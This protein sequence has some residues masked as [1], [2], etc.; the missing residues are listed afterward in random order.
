VKLI[1]L[2]LAET[3]L[4]QK[5]LLMPDLPAFAAGCVEAPKVLRA[6]TVAFFR[7]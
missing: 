7:M 2:S 5:E 1:E 3:I 4:S 6:V